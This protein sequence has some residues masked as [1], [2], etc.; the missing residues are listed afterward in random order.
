[1]RVLDDGIAF[2]RDFEKP[3]EHMAPASAQASSQHV[4]QPSVHASAQPD[5]VSPGARFCAVSTV[6]TTHPC[7]L[8][9][10]VTGDFIG[11]CANLSTVFINRHITV[12]MSDG[13]F[14]CAESVAV[15]H[16]E[17][18]DTAAQQRLQKLLDCDEPLSFGSSRCVQQCRDP[19]G[20]RRQEGR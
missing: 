2:L 6:Y 3:V 5:V 12:A 16:A 20:C 7:A 10:T 9:P 18:S 11:P 14:G 4:A 8:A 15:T 13:L 1:M 19:C 17:H